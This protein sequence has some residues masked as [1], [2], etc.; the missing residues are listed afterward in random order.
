M[1]NYNDYDE[2]II[3]S[4]YDDCD[5]NEGHTMSY[6]I[7]GHRSD[8]EQWRYDRAHH[9]N[10]ARYFHCSIPRNV[11]P[12][13]NAPIVQ[14]NSSLTHSDQSGDTYNEASITATQY[15]NECKAGQL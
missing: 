15:Q 3:L 5:G 6:S 14:M 7:C 12:M 9:H 13:H 2:F 8:L 4:K 1:S 10:E 11:L